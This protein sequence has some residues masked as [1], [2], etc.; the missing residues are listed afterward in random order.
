MIWE[1]PLEP[2]LITLLRVV[3]IKIEW[4]NV[5]VT[6]V[7]SFDRAT[8]DYLEVTLDVLYPIQANF[9]VGEPLCDLA[10]ARTPLLSSNNF[11]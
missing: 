11:N 9:V 10:T 8:C 7:G 3:L 1:C 2:Y 5:S 6:A 4:L